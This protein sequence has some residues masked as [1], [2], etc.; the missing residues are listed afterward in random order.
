MTIG[1]SEDMNASWHRFL[2]QKANWLPTVEWTVDELHVLVRERS[3]DGGSEMKAWATISLEDGSIRRLETPK[4]FYDV[5]QPAA[6]DEGLPYSYNE[7]GLWKK[8][9]V[10]NDA[11]PPSAE[12]ATLSVASYNVL[13]EFF[14][15][16]SQKRYPLVIKN[17]LS[18]KAKTDVLVLE[19][20]TDDF[21]S[22][23]LKDEAIQ[24][25]FPFCSWGPPDQED[26]EPLPSHN[27]IVILSKHMF[28]WKSVPFNREHKGAVVVTFS[29]I[30]QWDDADFK[31]LV[32]AALHLTHGLKDGSIT[33]KKSEIESILK[34]LSKNYPEHP[35][36][37]IGDFN[38]TTSSYTITQALEKNA[39]STQA[40]AH[41]RSF[42]RTFH[43]DGFV[44]TWAVSQLEKGTELSDVLETA[45]EGE[46]GATYDPTTNALA[47]EVVGSGFNMRPQRYDRIL[48]K[49]EDYFKVMQFNKFGFLTEALQEEGKVVNLLAS[50][51][52]GVR[53]ILRLGLQPESQRASVVGPHLVPVQLK[54]AQGSLADTES[55][56]DTLRQLQSIP[57]E[58]ETE[59]RASAFKLLQSV[60]LETPSSSF[61]TPADSGRSGSPLIVTSVG[62][63]G[64]GVWNSSSDIDCL[65]IGPFS[66]ST[67]F[68]LAAQRLRKASAKGIRI[69]R[70]VRAHTGTML[71]LDVQGIK[72]DLQYAPAH[73][74]AENWPAALG[75]PASNP[76]WALSAQTLNKLKAVRDLD[77]V[78]RSVPDIA[79]F[80]TAHRLIK[81]WAKIRG[82]YAAKYGYLSGI[83]ITILLARVYKLLAHEEAVVS[84]PDLLTT[85]FNHYA[86]FDWKKDLVFDPFFHKQLNYRR[87]DRDP[88]VITGYFPPSLNT[89]NTASVPSVRTITEEFQRADQLLQQEGMT[90]TQFLTTDD[91]SFLQSF[92]RYIKIDVQFWGGSLT[93]GRGFVGWLESRCVSLIVDLNRRL[94]ELH[95]RFWPARFV[96]DMA[97]AA[98]DEEQGS[99][100]GYYLIGIDKPKATV[101]D[102]K[103]M[104]DNLITI[105]A[106][107]CDQIR[108][109]KKYFDERTSLMTATVV[110]A[111]EVKSFEVDDR[112]WGEYTAGDEESDEEDEEDDGAQSSSIYEDYTAVHAS[113]KK[114][115]TTNQPRSVVVTKPEGAGKFRTAA[116]V[117]HRLRWDP[118]LDSGDHVVGY[119]DRFAGAMEKGLDLWKSEQTD[120]EFIPQHRILYFKRRSDGVVVWDRRSRTD[121]LFGS[122]G[123]SV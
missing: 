76:I 63:Y 101:A 103:V 58:E 87:T 123:P 73:A 36:I 18:D 90:W 92:R 28:E 85:F 35:M 24:A 111:A 86:S 12:V 93:K 122:G 65:C 17:I 44:D 50:D 79:N 118:A 121:L 29:A 81:E 52:W 56:L 39:V 78:R 84:V 4:P 49:G 91:G 99:Y 53:A 9:L 27:N 32:L 15:P 14:H 31:P 19:E 67:F 75:L 95:V 25:I 20:V 69:I 57:S 80:R 47:A 6:E 62:S 88:V 98:E 60:I 117:L 16:P 11:I 21:L 72:V 41:L 43:E 112:E 45:Y 64:L 54:N 113:A 102:E 61:S 42:D 1:Q 38:I 68:S 77:Y 100:Q 10:G 106:R 109:D 116:D 26:V 8:V 37:L 22:Y 97:A 96:E 120:D 70:R 55:L 33:A 119:E 74:I 115:R 59:R 48:V 7:S 46:Q 105:L 94:P 83:Q 89:A 107:F 23:L 110:K 13:A 2:L 108:G 30:G 66:S 82:V 104:Y 5:P 40:V 3:P 114:G 51:H 71:E 34:H